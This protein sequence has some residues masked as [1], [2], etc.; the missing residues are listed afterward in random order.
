[1][2]IDLDTPQ[3][4]AFEIIATVARL[5]KGAERDDV[6]EV[7]ADMKSYDFEH[8]LKVAER[9]CNGT[10]EFTGMGYGD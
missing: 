1:M 5:L 6:E 3:G 9:E 7:I 8:L 4:N 10:I 2:I